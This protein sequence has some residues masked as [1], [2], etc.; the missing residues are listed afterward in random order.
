MIYY[1]NVKEMIQG[2]IPMNKSSMQTCNLFNKINKQETHIS[3]RLYILSTAREFVTTLGQ[4]N[5]SKIK[6]IYMKDIYFEL[7]KAECI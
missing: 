2:K 6:I 5:N 4:C 7:I 3:Y 1:D